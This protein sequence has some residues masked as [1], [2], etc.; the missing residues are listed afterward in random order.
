V[1]EKLALV[2]F[3]GSGGREVIVVVGAAVSIVQ[4]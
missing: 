3:E 4:P 1:K 2:E